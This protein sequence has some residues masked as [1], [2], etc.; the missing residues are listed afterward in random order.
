MFPVQLPQ[1]CQ[2]GAKSAICDNL[3]NLA[4]TAAKDATV[5]AL[6]DI[7]KAEQMRRPADA[8][9]AMVAARA[10]PHGDNP[11]L[12]ASFA[13]ALQSGGAEMRT[14]AEAARVPIDPKALQ[15][16]ALQAY[17]YNPA[18]WTDLGDHFARSYD[19]MTAYALYDVAF[20]LPMPDAQRG[21]PALSGRR[22]R[23]ERL[24]RDFPAFFLD[25]PPY[26]SLKQ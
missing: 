18:Y 9:A 21:N 20:S 5:Q 16:R 26:P 6:L 19:V 15:V 7:T 12:G 10:T 2:S 3:R 4:A 1:S 23:A 22:G 13:L 14:Q 11:V 8:I 24:R 25:S 17:P